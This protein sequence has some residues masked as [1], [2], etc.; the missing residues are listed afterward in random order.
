MIRPRHALALLLAPVL[1][2]CLAAGPDGADASEDPSRLRV[3]LAFPPVD[4]LW[5]YGSDGVLLSRLG[6]TESLTALGDEGQ[7]VPALA[8]SWERENA[9]TWRFSLRLA[10]FHDGARMT[11]EA[12]AQSLNRA[13]GAAPVPAALTGVTLHA[14]PAEGNAVRVTTGTADP[15]LPLR[16]SSPSLAVLSPNAYGQNGRGG[17]AARNGRTPAADPVGHGTGPFAL[18]KVLGATAVTLDRYEGYW[19]GVPEAT[20]ADVRFI[21]DGAARAHALRSGQVDLAEAI[22]LAQSS[23]LREDQRRSVATTRTTSLYL[24]TR[25]KV[26]RRAGLRA[27]AR[28][29][30]DAPALVDAVYKGQADAGGGLYGP[31]RKRAAGGGHAVPAERAAPADPGG[32]TVVLATYDNRPELPELAQAVKEQLEQAGFRV[33]VEIREY[34]RIEPDVR[35]GRFD[36][37]LAARN[38]LLDTGDP[39]SFLA[40]DFTCGGGRNVARLCDEKVDRAVRAAAAQSD[41]GERRSAA[42]AAEA[43]I[44]RTDAVVP[45]AHPRV[46]TG[47]GSSVRGALL[48]PYERTL[49][50]K[51]TRR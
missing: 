28:A 45:L 49:I 48:D 41:P 32:R 37:F 33:E 27:A 21:A 12:V 40:S 22:P 18:T 7:A 16:L 14:E 8:T 13:A 43:E 15:A 29:A 5:P 44:L 50:G 1:T 34:A 23:A 6:V 46:V 26:F 35:E 17:N 51:Y 9:R 3:A 10:T 30:L 42:L 11:P 19:G 25:S 39:V 4:H 47:V 36:A 2:A 38:S 24:N 20:G 31:A